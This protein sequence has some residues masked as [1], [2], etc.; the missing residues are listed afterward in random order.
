MIPNVNTRDRKCEQQ[1][2]DMGKLTEGDDIHIVSR[3]CQLLRLLIDS[4]STK[5]IVKSASRH[6]PN[7]CSST[8]ILTINICLFLITFIFP[9]NS[10]SSTTSLSKPTLSE[11]R[12]FTAVVP[13][14]NCTQGAIKYNYMS[15]LWMMNRTLWD[16]PMTMGLPTLWAQTLKESPTS[17]WRRTLKIIATYE[18]QERRYSSSLGLSKH[19]LAISDRPGRMVKVMATLTSNEKL[20]T[21][22]TKDR[23]KLTNWRVFLGSKSAVRQTCV[24][25]TLDRKTRLVLREGELTRTQWS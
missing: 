5:K 2:R 20:K 4:L 22:T 13:F 21:Q 6:L 11:Y 25:Q 24:V 12:G 9:P 18:G 8:V 14:V 10:S 17:T 15:L 16:R 3:Y 7:R 1:L 19:P 23:F